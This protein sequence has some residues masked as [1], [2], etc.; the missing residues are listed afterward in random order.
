MLVSQDNRVEKKY[1]MKGKM[2]RIL[3]VSVRG[4]T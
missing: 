1:L 3:V 2:E 4:A